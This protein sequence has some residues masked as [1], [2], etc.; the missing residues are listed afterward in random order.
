MNTSASAMRCITAL[1]ICAALRTSMRSTFAGVG[2]RPCERESH[3]AGAR[4]GNAPHRVDC[5][6]RRTCRQEYALSVEN[7]GLPRSGDGGVEILRFEHP[8][9]AKLVAGQLAGIGAENRDAV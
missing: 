4:V 5:L 2:G 3:L 1:A 8:A 7:L 6:E 9:R